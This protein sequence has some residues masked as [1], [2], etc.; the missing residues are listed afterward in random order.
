MASFEQRS[1]AAERQG[2]VGFVEELVELELELYGT[3]IRERSHV[4]SGRAMA[5][6]TSK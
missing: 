3:E 5:L 1:Q 4:G 6:F 2:T